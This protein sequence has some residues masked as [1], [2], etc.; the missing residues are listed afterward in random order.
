MQLK[1]EYQDL[2]NFFTSHPLPAGPQHINEF[3]VFLN[4]SGAV[5][6]SLNQLRSDVEATSKSAATMLSEIKMWLIRQE[7]TTEKSTAGI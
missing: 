6:T 1:S 4:L 3:S 7:L 5:E 2:V